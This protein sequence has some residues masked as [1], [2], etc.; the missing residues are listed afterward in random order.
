MTTKAEAME[1]EKT[2]PVPERKLCPLLVISKPNGVYTSNGNC[3]E[4][5]C[6]MWNEYYGVCGLIAFEGWIHGRV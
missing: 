2:F 5:R 1:N 3:L 4:K 6:A